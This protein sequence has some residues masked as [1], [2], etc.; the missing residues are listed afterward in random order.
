M[1]EF[2]KSFATFGLAISIDKLIGLILLPIYTS[3]FTQEEYGIIEIIQSVISIVCIF[4]MLQLETSLQRY[5]YNYE[6][7]KKKKSPQ[8]FFI[9]L[10]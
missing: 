8:V 3:F 9:W 10:Y 2:F 7:Y 1:K 6:N 4:G 5:Y